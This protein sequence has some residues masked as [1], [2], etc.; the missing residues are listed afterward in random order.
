MPEYNL[1]AIRRRLADPDREHLTE[2]GHARKAQMHAEGVAESRELMSNLIAAHA[3]GPI[4]LFQSQKFATTRKHCNMLLRR[5]D[6][7]DPEILRKMVVV[8]LSALQ[9]RVAKY[10][11]VLREAPL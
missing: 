3:A 1:R 4:K 11:V 5:S 8:P 2:E 9:V 10:D 7:M 6:P